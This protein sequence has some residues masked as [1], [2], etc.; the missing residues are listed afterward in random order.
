MR[1]HSHSIHT[2]HRQRL[3]N[4]LLDI[5][6]LEFGDITPR[7]TN[8]SV[9]TLFKQLYEEFAGF[10][11]SKGLELEVGVTTARVRSDPA[12]I[13]EILHHL[14]SNAITY[15]IAGRVRL[16]CFADGARLRIEVHDTGIGIPADQL[17]RIYDPFYQAS[18]TDRP[19]TGYGLGLSV[20]Q[21][22]VS[23]LDLELDVHSEVGHGSTFALLLPSGAR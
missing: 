6:R 17:A 1:E 11:A 18:G 21:R 20:V 8:F 22:M 13:H 4:A 12:L 2:R 5:S 14:V 16:R 10:A 9:A 3:L 19:H 23:L 15:T 7:P